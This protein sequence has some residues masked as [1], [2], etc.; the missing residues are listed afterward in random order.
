MSK[1]D[2][3][4]KRGAKS[5][6]EKLLNDIEVINKALYLD[7][8]GRRSLMLQDSNY[9][10]PVGKTHLLDSKLKNKDDGKYSIEK[11]SK[12]SSWSWKGLKSLAVRNKKFNCCFFVQV[13]SIE[14]LPTLFDELCLVVHWKRRDG[15]LTTHHVVV[16]E[17]IAE[18]EEQLTHTC[19]ISGSKDG[20]N[21]SAKY[22]AKNFLL[23]PRFMVASFALDEL[24]ENSS[25]KRMTIFRLSGKAKGAILNVSFEYHIVGKTFTVF[26]SNKN[27]L[28]E[29]KTLR[30]N[31]EN[32]ANLLAQ[33]E[34]SDELSSTIRRAGS[35]PA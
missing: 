23:Y 25:G 13:H 1:V 32:A 28:L 17:G 12:K 21:Q 9:S 19:C 29:G 31:S 18:F 15:E 3:L 14:G 4:K 8:I 20:P 6:N 30:R 35:I 5:V 27:L 10:N 24:E 22:E 33:C 16:S 34:Q 11:E 2:S 7:K 26:P